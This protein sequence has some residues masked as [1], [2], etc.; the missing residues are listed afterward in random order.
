MNSIWLI[1]LAVM[2][3]SFIVQRMLTSRFD[4][5][6]RISLPS[7]LS[8]ADV[9]RKMLQENGIHDV[10][11][12]RGEGMLTDHYDPR[13]KVVKL[14]PA[15]Y[16]GCSIASAAVA[17]HECG[18]AVQHARH[19]LPLQLRSLLVPVVSFSNSIVQWV[20]LLGVLLLNV[21]PGLLWFGIILFAAS[22]LFSVITL[23]VEI[24]ASA[25]A[26]RWLSAAGIADSY[27]LPKA[28]DALKWAAY[29]YVIAAIGSIATLLY[30]I[31]IA[32][33]RRD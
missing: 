11:V 7:G 30:Y 27:T 28:K 13:A 4:K 16:D 15:V 24:N 6:Q 25:R 21:F 2:F 23:P 29:T 9:A 18:H 33:S 20:L 14:S 10:Q 32:N 3:A 12:L 17:A 19:Y 5:Y 31:G 1:M 22:T 26:I 8:G